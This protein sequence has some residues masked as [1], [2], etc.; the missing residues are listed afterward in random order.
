M[1]PPR[2]SAD[3]LLQQAIENNVLIKLARE[4]LKEMARKQ[5]ENHIVTLALKEHKTIDRVDNLWEDFGQMKFLVR[6][7]L[8]MA[9]LIPALTITH[10]LWHWP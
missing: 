7:I 3:P 8:A 10:V 1:A 5:D 9:S 6:V 4:D 2:Q